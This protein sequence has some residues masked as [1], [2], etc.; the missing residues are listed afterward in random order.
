MTYN[1]YGCH[2]RLP[3]AEHYFASGGVIPIKNV[4]ERDCQY[5]KTEIG[6][7]DGSCEGCKHK[8]NAD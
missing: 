6:K 3:F 4:F 5:T 1:L 8:D 7:T 2:N